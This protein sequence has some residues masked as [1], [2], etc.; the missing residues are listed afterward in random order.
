VVSGEEYEFTSSLG[1]WITV[2]E[3]AV[4][5]TVLVDGYSPVSV[6]TSS[7]QDLYVHWNVNDACSTWDDCTLTTIECVNC[8]VPGSPCDNAMVIASVPVF[9]QSIVCDGSNDITSS[10]VASIC[11]SSLY[12]GG[13]DALYSFTP[14][15]TADYVVSISGVSY[16]GIMV[17]EGCPVPGTCMENVSGSTTSKNVTVSL[18]MGTEY[19][20]MFD[21]WPSPNSP[22]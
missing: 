20:I 8:P 11:G 2:R 9:S 7:T 13:K 5:G 18:T 12:Y 17:Y 21:T 1:S 15:T 19:F 10:N 16:S 22:C 4:G 14:A 3:G 6:I